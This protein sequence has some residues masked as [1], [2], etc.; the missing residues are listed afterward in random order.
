NYLPRL[1]EHTVSYGGTELATGLS[2]RL[3][4]LYPQPAGMYMEKTAGGYRAYLSRFGFN[5][6]WT[7]A[8]G[9]E[10]A[11][12]ST[13]NYVYTRQGDGIWSTAVLSLGR[14]V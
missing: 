10:W 12:E 14:K 8:N 6:T 5:T 2:D 3:K 11:Q 1:L 7:S 13:M 9:V 4:E